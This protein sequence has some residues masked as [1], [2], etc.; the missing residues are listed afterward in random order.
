MVIKSWYI[1]PLPLFYPALLTCDFMA[2]KGLG[3]KFKFIAFKTRFCV[4]SKKL[5]HNQLI[6]WFKMLLMKSLFVRL[7]LN[8]ERRKCAEVCQ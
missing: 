2:V 5:K 4:L 6:S 8:L 3:G 7:D 1:T